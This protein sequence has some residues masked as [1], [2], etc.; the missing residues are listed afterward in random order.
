MQ[1]N[2]GSV[3]LVMLSE[4]TGSEATGRAVETSLPRRLSRT[5]ARFS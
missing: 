1:L 2:I 3:S 5:R 4:V